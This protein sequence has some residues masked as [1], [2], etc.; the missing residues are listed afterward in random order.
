MVIDTSTIAITGGT[1]EVSNIDRIMM[2]GTAASADGQSFN[3]HLNGLAAVLNGAI[4][5]DLTGNV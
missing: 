5:S 4:I 2:E 3:W 1:G